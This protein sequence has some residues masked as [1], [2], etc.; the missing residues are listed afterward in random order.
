MK[1]V[2]LWPHGGRAVMPRK[3]SNVPH[4]LISVEQQP[5]RRWDLQDGI[6]IGRSVTC[7][8]S[9]GDSNLSRRHCRL[10]RGRS[11]WFIVDQRSRNGTVV[12]GE[13][14]M[15]RALRD[16]DEIRV[17]SCRIVFCQ[18]L[19][20]G[21]EDELAMALERH[22][23]VSQTPNSSATVVTVSAAP[24][25]AAVQT[26]ASA[27]PAAGAMSSAVTDSPESPTVSVAA[28]P[29]AAGGAAVRLS[30]GSATTRFRPTGQDPYELSPGLS[31]PAVGLGGA[32]WIRQS[33]EEA[34][35]LEHN[36]RSQRFRGE[37]DNS[38]VQVTKSTWVDQVKDFIAGSS[39]Q[40]KAIVA[41]V[42]AG[43]V[44][45]ALFL[46]APPMSAGAAQARKLARQPIDAKQLEWRKKYCAGD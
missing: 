34:D 10:E 45:L 30:A 43:V 17:G 24:Q 42:L 39:T 36:D 20:D 19:A 16:G 40:Q 21:L 32:S 4:L 26:S 1:V 46:V 27:S 37:V 31:R 33:F 25:A 28:V 7:D 14:I 22:K 13:L 8:L 6:T 3:E 18:P 35:A 29:T 41:A 15:R 23:R 12:N 5:P 9:L 2:Q 44:L 38:H 11:G